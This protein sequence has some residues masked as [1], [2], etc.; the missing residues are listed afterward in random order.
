MNLADLPTKRIASDL[1]KQVENFL[2][3]EAHLLDEW[4]LEEWL[5]LFDPQAKYV[6]PTTDLPR[7][8]PDI[9]MTLISDDLVRLRQR[10]DQLLGEKAWAEFPHSRTRRFISNVLV[11]AQDDDI[12]SVTANFLVHRFRHGRC[13]AFVGQYRHQVRQAG[14]TFRFKTRCAVLD[15]ET[16]TPHAMVSFIL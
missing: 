16:L 12:L 11:H 13:N 15:H 2:Y 8:R 6:V 14:E 10:V 9:D 7:P 4:Q 5:T 1:T 3:M